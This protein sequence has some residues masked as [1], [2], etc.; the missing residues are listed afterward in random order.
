[1]KTTRTVNDY[2]IIYMPEHPKA[3]STSNWKGWVYEHIVVAE[4]FKGR[5]LAPNEVVHHLDFNRS[6]NRRENLLIL[7]RGEHAKLH[8]WLDK[9]APG[10][11]QSGE[12]RVNSRKP[13]FCKV[14]DKTLQNKAKTYC[15]DNC[16]K[17]DSRRAERPSQE[18]LEEEIR[19]LGFEGTG[20]KYGVS[21]NAVRKWLRQS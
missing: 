6:N 11:Q 17:Y 2:R 19:D 3:M 7:D 15:S 14:C 10:W 20:R 13:K 8:S 4:K 16:S 12:N 18:Q 21:G 1:M 5:S 9:G